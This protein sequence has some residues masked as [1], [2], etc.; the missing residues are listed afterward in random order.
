M[1]GNRHP[2]L[3]GY[4]DRLSARPGEMV[5]VKVSSYLEDDFEA[6]LARIIC[7]D[8]N[9]EGT[10]LIEESHRLRLCWALSLAHSTVYAGIVHARFHTAR[11]SVA[12]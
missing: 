1:N 4:T 7:A 10:G 3:L 9:P 5:Q 2:P 8:P 12:G 6:D 11:D